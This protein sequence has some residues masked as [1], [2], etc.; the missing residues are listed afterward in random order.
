M[1]SESFRGYS[2]GGELQVSA[3]YLKGISSRLHR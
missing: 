2:E 1:G 3:N